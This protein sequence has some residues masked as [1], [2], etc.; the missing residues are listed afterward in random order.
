MKKI[1]LNEESRKGVG[2]DMAPLIDCVFLLL[3]FFVVA[4][5]FTAET[6]LDI[7]RPA[8]TTA[9]TL[10]QEALRVVLTH[11]GRLLCDGL[12]TTYD[13][14]SSAVSVALDGSTTRPVVLFTDGS[15]PTAETIRLVDACRRGGAARIAIATQEN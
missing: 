5:V 10:P 3:I 12:E 6:G 2:I 11:D 8:A 7:E 1:Q 13:E 9:E 4:S 14:L 15:L